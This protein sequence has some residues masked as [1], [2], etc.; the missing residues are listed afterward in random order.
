[1]ATVKFYAISNTNYNLTSGGS[2]TFAL[3][4]EGSLPTQ[5]V[6]SSV[7]FRLSRVYSYSLSR[8]F[9]ILDGNGNVIAA[10]LLGDGSSAA[11]NTYADLSWNLPVTHSLYENLS[12]LTIRGSNQSGGSNVL[13]IRNS[14]EISIS[15]E[16]AAVTLPVLNSA[17]PADA[18]MVEGSNPRTLEVK[19]ATDGYP[20]TYAYQWYA[21]GEAIVGATNRTVE[22]APSATTTYH[23]VVTNEAGSVAS[24]TSTLTYLYMPTL[25]AAYPANT[26]SGPDG[27]TLEVRIIRA[28]YPADHKYQWYADGVAIPGATQ[29]TVLV[30]PTSTTKYHCVVTTSVGSVSSRVAT[31]T[32]KSY[33]TPTLDSNYPV[34]LSVM[35]GTT[36][37]LEVKVATAGY[38]ADYTYQWYVSDK[39]LANAN[40]PLIRFPANTSAKYYCEVT[41]AAGTVRSRTAT[42]AVQTGG[43]ILV[44]GGSILVDGAWKP[45]T[46]YVYTNGAWQLATPYCYTDGAWQACTSG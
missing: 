9:D 41:N 18:Y 13:N 23:C 16:Y 4:T 8:G 12:S 1:M 40:G 11:N 31:V 7:V 39:P 26:E 24:R 22:V 44:D 30:K 5:C 15:I 28:G 45:V 46:V 43:S 2:K 19:I 34:D 37:T 42:V 36:V 29:R 32:Y 14:C 25:D 20:A 33:Y 6:I 38:P 3:T 35:P 17:Y 21:N 27:T 10:N